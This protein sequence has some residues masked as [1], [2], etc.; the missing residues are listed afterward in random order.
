MIGREG[1]ASLFRGHH[2]EMGDRAQSGERLEREM[3][4]NH[5]DAR[6][7]E[8]ISIP[9]RQREIALT[10]RQRNAERTVRLTS[11][12]RNRM[13][14]PGSEGVQDPG[15]RIRPLDAEL[16]AIIHFV[17][18]PGHIP[19]AEALVCD[20]VGHLGV[21]DVDV[22]GHEGVRRIR[23]H[24]GLLLAGVPPAGRLKSGRGSIGDLR[25]AAVLHWDPVAG[26]LRA[27]ASDEDDR[28][29]IARV[30]TRDLDLPTICERG[31]P[32]FRG[33]VLTGAK[34]DFHVADDPLTAVE[35][36]VETLAIHQVP[37]LALRPRGCDGRIDVAASEAGLSKANAQPSVVQRHLSRGSILTMPR[38]SPYVDVFRQGGGCQ[39]HHERHEQGD[40]F[41]HHN[42]P[43][44]VVARV[45]VCCGV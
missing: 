14:T 45:A 39:C 20:H 26:R 35:L 12:Q 37:H 5:L 1:E 25:V 30:G 40:E 24:E 11:W 36:S 38:H 19:V 6:Q 13:G 3:V 7:N 8:P 16:R 29:V 42:S 18:E 10:I 32:A 31:A 9:K 27:R 22:N 41:P 43:V 2:I 23:I 44:A 15:V 4:W 17:V 34:R 28:D 21:S 33:P